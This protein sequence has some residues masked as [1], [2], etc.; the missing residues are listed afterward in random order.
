MRSVAPWSAEVG[1][2][3]QQRAERD[4]I[5]ISECGVPFPFGAAQRGAGLSKEADAVG[6][7]GDDV[8][9]P[10]CGIGFAHDQTSFCRSSTSATTWLGSSRRN[11]AIS[12]CDGCDRSAARART[13]YERTLSPKGAR[14]ALPA[15]FAS[16]LARASRKLRSSESDSAGPRSEAS[17]TLAMLAERERLNRWNRPRKARGHHV[18]RYAV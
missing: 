17:V 5:L 14:A 16:A 15:A 10:I 18:T 6:R 12:R 9:A 1:D 7:R 2:G 8:R 4:A 11:S 3:A 13:E